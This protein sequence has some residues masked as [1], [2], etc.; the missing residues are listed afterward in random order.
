[1]NHCPRN[2][3]LSQGQISFPWTGVLGMGAP[4]TGVPVMGVP[5]TGVP[6]T[7]VPVKQMFQG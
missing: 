7:G 1:M 5:G 4:G 6:G 3:C 2:E